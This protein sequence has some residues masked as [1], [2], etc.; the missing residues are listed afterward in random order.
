MLNKAGV[1]GGFGKM[2]FKLGEDW[3]AAQ[4]AAEVDPRASK[5]FI[6]YNRN[7][8]QRMDELLNLRM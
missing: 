2:D 7:A 3:N 5:A 4:K 1:E 8:N 6:D